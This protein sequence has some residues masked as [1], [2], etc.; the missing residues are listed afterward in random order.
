MKQCRDLMQTDLRVVSSAATAFEAARIM[1]DHSVGCL[2]VYDPMTRRLAG[3]VTDRD[4]VTRMCAD[5]KRPSE[6]LVADVATAAP[7]VCLPSDSIA[8][9]EEL[10]TSLDISRV[11]IVDEDDHPIGILS[12]TDIIMHDRGGR[13]LR[14]AR[15]VLEREAAGPHPPIE[16]IGLT[17]SDPT[18][19]PSAAPADEADSPKSGTAMDR[20][21]YIAGGRE[22]SGM[23]EFPR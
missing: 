1:R 10:M 20:R 13:A 4:L 7:A 15:G 8:S 14:T 21:D 9:A 16:S 22:T 11:M 12:L 23:K 17:P 18:R 6:S 2:P 5:D 3:V 19:A